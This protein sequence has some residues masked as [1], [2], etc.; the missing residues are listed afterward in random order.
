MLVY[1]TPESAFDASRRYFPYEPQYTNVAG[2]GEPPLMMASYETGNVD[3][4]EVALLLHGEPTWSFLY[5]HMAPALASKGF[6]VLMPDVIGMGRSDKPT[7]MSI[8]SYAQHTRWLASWM[9]QKVAPLVTDPAKPRLLTIFCQDW[10]SLLGLRAISALPQLAARIVIGN[11]GLPT[12]HN[13]IPRAFHIWRLSSWYSP[14]FPVSWI[15]QLGT[16]TQM[17][18]DEKEAYDAPFVGNSASKVGFH[19]FV[20]LGPP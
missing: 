9:L 17:S 2:P 20:R 11:G 12:G 6:L 3:A 19:S 13:P 14:I 1:R 16:K 10:G 4:E 5:R 7:D 15:V 18:K 8:F